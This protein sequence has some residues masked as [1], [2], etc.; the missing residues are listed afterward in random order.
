M[1]AL[2][3]TELLDLLGKNTGSDEV[4]AR[5]REFKHLRNEPLYSEPDEFRSTLDDVLRVRGRPDFSRPPGKSKWADVVGAMVRFDTPAKSVHFQ[6]RV[7]GSGIELV[8]L[9]SAASLHG[10]PFDD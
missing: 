10:N 6:F 9:M 1:A 2:S 4:S 8:T 5:L 7:D 3:M